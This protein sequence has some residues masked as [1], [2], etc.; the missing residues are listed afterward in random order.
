MSCTWPGTDREW[1]RLGGGGGGAELGGGGGGAA[2][3]PSSP[4]LLASSRMTAHPAEAA[5][6]AAISLLPAAASPVPARCLFE[7]FV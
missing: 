6:E 4:S 1:I 7:S 2:G 5:A 3:S